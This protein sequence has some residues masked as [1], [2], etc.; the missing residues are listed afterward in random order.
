M[1]AIMDLSKN[2]LHAILDIMDQCLSISNKNN[3]LAVLNQ[4]RNILP[5]DSAALAIPDASTNK[6]SGHSTKLIC[7][8][9][10]P[11]WVSTYIK[12]KFVTADLVVTSGCNESVLYSWYDA[13][14]LY[15]NMD[16]NLSEYISVVSNHRLDE[17]C[18]NN[19]PKLFT[20]FFSVP[21]KDNNIAP[22]YFNILE[23]VMPH[24]HEAVRRLCQSS[25]DIEQT[26]KFN[27]NKKID[28]QV[29]KLLTNR[30]QEILKWAVRGKTSWEIGR[31]LS[32]S[33]RTVKFHFKNTYEKL[34]VVNRSQAVA[35][36]VSQGFVFI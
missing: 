11:E 17:S 1:S 22:R 20:T 26:N 27:N 19:P 8:S 25:V 35:K 18:Y 29:W 6:L 23:H 5:F 2:E 14:F 7:H 28:Q 31:I 4:I 9:Y 12:N 33:E 36:A 32:I 10:S 13:Y 16:D 3:L 21:S 34:N 24:L 15:E 30:E